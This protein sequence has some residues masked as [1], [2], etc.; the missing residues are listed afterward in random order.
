MTY[1]STYFRA[2]KWR[3]RRFHES[4]RMETLS[5]AVSIL[6]TFLGLHSCGL[7]AQVQPNSETPNMQDMFSELRQET[8][9]P[10]RLSAG[11]L[12][13][14]KPLPVT[15]VVN[16]TAEGLRLETDLWRIEV[17]KANWQLRLT[18]KHSG[19]MW[20]LV[21]DET[22][23]S[24]VWWEVGSDKQNPASLFR[25]VGIRDVR[26]E[27]NRWTMLGNIGPAMQPVKLE[28]AVL[29]PNTIRLSFV[30]PPLGNNPRL[31]LS[32]HGAGPFFGLGEQFTKAKLDGS[33]VTLR[34]AD[35]FV[36]DLDAMKSQSRN[37][38]HSTASRHN[39]TYVPVPFLFSPLGLGLYVDTAWP[40]TFDLTRAERQ[41]F[42]VELA[43]PSTDCYFFIADGPK[44][45]IESYTGLTGRTPLPPP[46]A[47]GVWVNVT[48]GLHDLGAFYDEGVLSEARRLRELRIPTSALWIQD[49]VDPSANMGW[50]FWTV[51]YYGQ[52]RQVTEDLHGLG[53]KVLAYTNPWV[54]SI[55]GPYLLPNPTYQLGEHD[56]NFVLGPDGRVTSPI[57]FE[58]IPSGNIDFTKP[59]AVNWWGRMKQKTLSEHGFD[60]WMEDFGEQVQDTDRFAV[61]KTGAELANLYPLLYHKT[62]REFAQR[63]NP[64]VVEF[65][66]SGYAGSQGY[67]PILWGGDQ[68]PNWDPDIGLPTLLPA[69]ITAGLSGFAIWGPDIQ[70][71]GTSKELW[72]RW[73]E[74]GA[75]SPIM[76]DHKW[77]QPKWAVDL[78]FDSETTELFRRYAGIH[79]SLFPYLYSYAHQATQTGLPLI[80][81]LMLEYPD[82]PMAWNAENEYLLGEKILVAPVVTP[83]ATTRTLYLPKG[84][85]M[86]YWTGKLIEGG[87]LVKM[88]APLDQ[89]PILIR[90]GSLIPLIDPETQTLADDLAQGQYQ[91]LDNNLTLR[92]IPAAV[93]SDDDFVL[94][95][96]TRASVRQR[97]SSVEVRGQG[98]PLAR[99]Y[100]VVLSA[101]GV[102]ARVLL[103]GERLERLDD[104]GYR[105]RRKGWWMSVDQ[106]TLHVLFSASDFALEVLS[107]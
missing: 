64:N 46:W 37:A 82:D 83:G 49:I 87:R 55:L 93:P 94:A 95:D 32:F 51:G 35:H 56:G 2:E 38:D 91:T 61:G 6:A 9:S 43:G 78:W 30:P 106:H 80:R 24:S 45:I 7:L 34:T 105:V 22:N 28:I 68:F 71:G 60:G 27:G 101:T 100:E 54:S 86:D 36:A 12:L 69:G 65:S 76:R 57:L 84:S 18:N 77:N 4:R 23:P 70:S 39:W 31:G 97:D 16:E 48:K 96:G 62:S 67:T 10:S 17:Q 58:G 75:L 26:R 72:I 29:T 1:R 66:R 79:M 13:K 44:G 73:L 98:A 63:T 3:A 25:L 90:S 21:P 89:I 19:A 81:H 15:L 50:P 107:R 102:P 11:R 20:E 14:Q 59:E 103:S 88:P 99:Q 104:I 33:K 47:F 74:L 5:M 41:K 92:V 40:S 85:W 42:S 52:P 53:F 8:I